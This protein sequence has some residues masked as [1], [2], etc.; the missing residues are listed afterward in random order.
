MKRFFTLALMLMLS[1]AMF[2]KHV[3]RAEALRVAQTVL[4]ET[5]L[6]EVAARSY[7]N[8]YIFNGEHAFVIVSADDCVIPILAY[9]EDFAFRVDDMP[10]NIK[11]WMESLDNE[12]QNAINKNLVATNEIRDE[13]DNLKNGNK[14]TPKNR[15][16]V[17]PLIKTHWDQG[18]PYNNMCPGG[19]V[20]GCAATA[21]AQVMKYWEWPKTGTGSHTYSHSSYGNLTANFGNTTYD[22]DNMID[23]PTTSSSTAQQNAVATLMYHC[24]VAL[25]MN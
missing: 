15:T 22:W 19:S 2:A 14:P 4:P 3:E 24:G 1:V 12:I 6:T 20:T 18:A 25:D 21:L 7:A 11:T 16:F 5:T 23:M 9:S 8:M 10:G 13:W 17:R